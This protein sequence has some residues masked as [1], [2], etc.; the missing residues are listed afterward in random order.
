MPLRARCIWTV[1]TSHR[2]ACGYRSASMDGWMDDCCGSRMPL[3][4][5]AARSM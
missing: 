1:I 3:A 5:N 4:I 2:M